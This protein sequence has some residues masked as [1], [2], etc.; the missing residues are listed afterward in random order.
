MNKK[1]LE[2][3]TK[4][5][6]ELVKDLNTQEAYDVFSDVFDENKDFVMIPMWMIAA[7]AKSVGANRGVVTL[8]QDG[9]ICFTIENTNGEALNFEKGD[10]K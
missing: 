3:I 1:E 6:I 10:E 7:T 9:G 2:K 8:Q 5:V 4:Q